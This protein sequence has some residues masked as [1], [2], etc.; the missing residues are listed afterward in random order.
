MRHTLPDDFLCLFI[1][2]LIN[3]HHKLVISALLLLNLHPELLIVYQ[4]G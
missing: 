2:W 3:F 4:I 1:S